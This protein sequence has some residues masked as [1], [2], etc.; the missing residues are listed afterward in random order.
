LQESDV[1]RP[2][3]GRAANGLLLRLPEAVR[4]RLDPALHL[5]HFSRQQVLFR[6]G[7]P[8]HAVYFPVNSSVSFVTRVESGH[9]LEVAFVGPLGLVGATAL[10][11][12]VVGCDAIVQVAGTAYRMDV[13]TFRHESAAHPPLAFAVEQFVELLLVRTAH[14]AACNM[15]HS[16]EQRCV[17]WLLTMTDL[18][19]Q[20]AIA[21]THETLAAM[22]GMHRPTVSQVLGH[23]YRDGRIEERRGLVTIADRAALQSVAC[24][25]FE[26]MRLARQQ[27][28]SA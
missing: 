1:V 6:S 27:L 22:L 5:V 12:S 14:L 24:E 20:D 25:C 8:L 2:A 9:T 23:L 4:E 7:E 21:V 26:R 10:T 16:A 18:V 13:S 28:L 15:F 11:S 3:S 17:R 19:G